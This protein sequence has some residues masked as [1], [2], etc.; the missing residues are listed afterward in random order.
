MDKEREEYEH[1]MAEEEQRAEQEREERAAQEVAE[2]ERHF[3]D[4]PHG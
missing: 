1:M 2:M 4:H 3:R